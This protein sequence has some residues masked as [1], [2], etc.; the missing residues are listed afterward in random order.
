MI[1][2]T[3]IM[4]GIAYTSALLG[5]LLILGNA[6]PEDCTSVELYTN[7]TVAEYA[8]S[9]EE[10][11]SCSEKASFGLFLISV[12][13]VGVACITFCILYARESWM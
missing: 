7:G 6:I 2:T 4:T 5:C 8:T 12:I 3:L 11:D 10:V 13:P 1:K 9:V